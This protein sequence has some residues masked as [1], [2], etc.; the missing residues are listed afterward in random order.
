M[1]LDV[2]CFVAQRKS[3]ISRGMES[4][5]DSRRAMSV[6]MRVKYESLRAECDRHLLKTKEL[7]AAFWSELCT[8]SPSLFRLD[9]VGVQLQSSIRSAEQAFERLLALNPSSSTTRTLYSEFLMDVRAC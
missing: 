5:S 8:R 1:A 4:R 6:A 2:A 9:S 3:D 7:R